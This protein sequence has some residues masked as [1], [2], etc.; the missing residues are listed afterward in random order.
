M[1]AMD[2]VV[3]RDSKREAACFDGVLLAT[4]AYGALLMLHFQFL[5]SLMARPKRGRVFWGLVTYSSILFPLATISIGGIFKF[6]ELTY[7]DNNTYTDGPTAYYV[8]HASA[9]VNVMSQIWCDINLLEYKSMTNVYGD[10]ETILPWFADTLMAYRLMVVWNYKWWL[11]FFPVPMYLGRLV[12]SVPILLFAIRSNHASI[13]WASPAGA[14]GTVYFSICF[15]LNFMVTTAIC[16]RL[17][18]LRPK[19]EQALGKL[20]AAFYTSPCTA[21]VESGAFFTIWSFCHLVARTKNSWMQE[22]FFQPY[23][24]V[25]AITRS[26]VILRMAQDHAWTKEVT[27]ATMTGVLDWQVSSM[28]SIPLHDVAD[29]SASSQRQP[30]P[31]KFRDDV[32]S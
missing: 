30:L 5:Q 9:A 20:Q 6:A 11:L 22:I 17:W 14:F 7:V 18:M 29:S 26:M 4:L 31:K 32:L 3:E 19:C 21:F 10:S 24:Y 13:Q 27:V 15:A 28:H 23:T 1:S 8:A 25:L 12:L 2:N 16:F